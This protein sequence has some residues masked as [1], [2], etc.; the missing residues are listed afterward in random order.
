EVA[1]GNQE[2]KKTFQP[3]KQQ[4]A[5]HRQ[6]LSEKKA[7]QICPPLKNPKR[8]YGSRK[9]EIQSSASDEDSG[10]KAK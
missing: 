7:R 2:R 9:G 1:S 10:R 6:N 5:G 4:D 8:N 3:W